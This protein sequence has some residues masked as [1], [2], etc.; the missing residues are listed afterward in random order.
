[1]SDP[2][3]MSDSGQFQAWFN[4]LFPAFALFA[5]SQLLLFSQLLLRFGLVL[6]WF[7]GLF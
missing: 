7:L 1:M 2:G 3:E 5:L 4:A 6:A